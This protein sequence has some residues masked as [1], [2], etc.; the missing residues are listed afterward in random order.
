MTTA[1]STWFATSMGFRWVARNGG[2]DLEPLGVVHAKCM[3]T[4]MTACGMSSSSW[5]KFWD[6]PF[7]AVVRPG[8]TVCPACVGQVRSEV[9]PGQSSRVP[10]T[11]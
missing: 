6:H 9:G 11:T 4:T 5:K 2:Y 7:D 3:G 10:P 8:A 1:Q